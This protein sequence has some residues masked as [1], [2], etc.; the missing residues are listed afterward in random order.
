MKMDVKK[1]KIGRINT[2]SLFTMSLDWLKD[3]KIIIFNIRILDY[4]LEL[5]F[6]S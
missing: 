1:G 5:T 2:F 3:N 4:G 6:Y